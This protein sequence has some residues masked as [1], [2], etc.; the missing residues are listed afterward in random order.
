MRRAMPSPSIWQVRDDMI[1]SALSPILVMAVA[2]IAT[3]LAGELRERSG[4]GL[5]AL[6]FAIFLLGVQAV[7]WIRFG[8]KLTEPV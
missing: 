7:L 5:F 4:S 8:V 6:L 2:F 3:A 1:L